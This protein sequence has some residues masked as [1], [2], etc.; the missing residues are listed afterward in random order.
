MI[1]DVVLRDG[2]TLHMRPATLSDRAGLPVTFLSP[3]GSHGHWLSALSVEPPARGHV[4]VGEVGGQLHV[5]AGYRRTEAT[6]ED[7]AEVAMAVA[8]GFAWRGIGTRALLMLAAQARSESVRAFGARVPRGGRTGLK[9][10]DGQA[11][12]AQRQASLGLVLTEALTRQP[13]LRRA[14]TSLT[15]ATYS[16]PCQV[17][18]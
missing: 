7:R 1:A 17:E 6:G 9:I 12:F 16:Q 3:T 2:S 4:I 11:I 15:K 18:T 13:T 8:P 10:E 14:N 5:V